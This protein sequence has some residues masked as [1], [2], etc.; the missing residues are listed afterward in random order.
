MDEKHT[1]ERNAT[2]PERL[3]VSP[4]D[5]ASSLM[6]SLLVTVGLVT[7]LLV[8]GWLS[9]IVYQ[10]IKPPPPHG[11]VQLV[12]PGGGDDQ[13]SGGSQLDDLTNEP[14]VGSDPK[15]IDPIRD[16]ADIGGAAGT[17][18]AAEVDDFSVDHRERHG[19]RGTGNGWNG[20]D[21][22]GGGRREK[23]L[24]GQERPQNWEVVFGKGLT[25][26]EY[27][28]RLDFF[29]IELGVVQPDGKIEYAFHL[30]K[31]KPDTRTVKEG[32]KSEH[33]YWLRWTNGELRKA[34]EELLERAGIN[35]NEDWLLKFVPHETEIQLLSLEKATAGPN[36]EDTV[37]R[38]RFGVREAGKGYAFFVVEQTYK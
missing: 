3:D 19:S 30:S 25:L 11:P 24:P 15:S 17:A 34:D 35:P 32:Y 18:S 7:A 4:Y 9:L 27:A 2:E 36:R 37:K 29:N 6:I 8:A 28:R 5:R 33:R 13:K 26:D 16:A 1:T 21:G 12:G 20:G 38:T 23:R 22:P 10:H 14:V 31:P